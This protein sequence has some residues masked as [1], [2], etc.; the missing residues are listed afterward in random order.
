MLKNLTK[1]QQYLSEQRGLRKT[2]ISLN[3]CNIFSVP[4]LMNSIYSLNDVSRVKL[5]RLKLGRAVTFIK[6]LA[7]V[8][9]LIFLVLSLI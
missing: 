1:M 6:C 2:E 4:Y 9:S 7:S 5:G 3:L 8:V